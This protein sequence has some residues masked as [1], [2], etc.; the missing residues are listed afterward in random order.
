MQLKDLIQ[1]FN[2]S[3]TKPWSDAHLDSIEILGVSLIH[4]ADATDISFALPDTSDELIQ[5]CQASVLIVSRHDSRFKSI[6]ILHHD[7]KGLYST[8]GAAFFRPFDEG[9]GID[10][11]AIVHPTARIGKNVRIFANSV[12]RENV[13]IGD[14]C[15]LYPGTYIDRNVSIGNHS[16]L[17]PN[18]VIFRDTV[19]GSRTTIGAGSVIGVEAFIHRRDPAT[20]EDIKQYSFGTTVVGNDVDIGALCSIERAA[21]S[22]DFTFIKGGCK[23]N[24][25]IH[26]GHD[27]VLGNNCRLSAQV[28]IA[29]QTKVGMQGIIYGQVGIAHSITIG[30][31]VTIGGGSGV[32]SAIPANGFYAGYPAVP[33]REWG[34]QILRQRGLKDDSPTQLLE[35]KIKDLEQ[36][37]S[38]LE[39]SLVGKEC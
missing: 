32:R 12:V 25:M 21:N 38:S 17:H 10:S 18:V 13:E 3:T 20:H 8:L 36:R 2:L 29:G 11:L 39:S 37:L 6:Q 23:L 4:N 16:I 5:S 14:N 24:D 27:V 19:I 1:K 15:V 30:D 33:F 9:T 26:I 31:N 35:T 22:G 28:G 34:R 7:P